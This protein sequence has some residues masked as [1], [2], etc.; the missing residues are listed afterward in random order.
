MQTWKENLQSVYIRYGSNITASESQ[1]HDYCTKHHILPLS[2]Q[3]SKVQHIRAAWDMC[4]YGYTSQSESKDLIFSRRSLMT[5]GAG[6]AER[7]LPEPK[8]KPTQIAC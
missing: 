8:T 4:R 5:P 3:C 2:G 1:V 6:Q 7:L